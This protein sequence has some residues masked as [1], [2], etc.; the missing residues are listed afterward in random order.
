MEK[1]IRR[2]WKWQVAW[3]QFAASLTGSRHTLEF[4]LL[5]LAIFGSLHLLYETTQGTSVERL[6][7]NDL[8]VKP[9]ATV[10]NLLT[11]A[12]QVTAIGHR[13]VSPFAGLSVLNGCEG[14]ET[15][16][17]LGAAILAFRTPWR[18][19]AIGRGLRKTK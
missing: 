5:F 1:Q 8:T 16:L 2:K 7:I 14:T 13:L 9:S 19:K 15:I 6:L 10:I 12:E 11:P 17:L 4:A 18:D 3:R